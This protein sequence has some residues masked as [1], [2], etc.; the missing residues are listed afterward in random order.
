VEKVEKAR[1]RRMLTTNRNGGG[2]VKKK[3]QWY[4]EEENGKEKRKVMSVLY[5]PTHVIQNPAGDI[6][7]TGTSASPA[8]LLVFNPDPNQPP[9]P[10]K[11]P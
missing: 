1:D 6:K 8:I 11:T 10:Q 2:I 3:R 7:K 9:Q 5:N 4:H